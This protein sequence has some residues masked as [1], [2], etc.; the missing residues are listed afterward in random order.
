VYSACHD[1][2][3]ER[4][5]SLFLGEWGLKAAFAALAAH[6]MAPYGTSTQLGLAALL[7][8]QHLDCDNYAALTGHFVH[9]L[10]PDHPNTFAVI[11]LDGGKLGN[12]AQVILK[13]GQHGHI[14]ADPTVG[15]IAA[16]S[17]NKLLSGKPVPSEKVQAFYAHNDPQILKFGKVVYDTITSGRIRPSNMLYYFSDLQEY[18]RFS[19]AVGSA[20]TDPP[21]VEAIVRAFPTPGV[22]A[23]ERDL[24]ATLHKDKS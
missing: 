12:H 20:W 19:Y 9:I 11:G 22:R 1:E 2:L 15:I 7:R 3:S 24:T 5:A 6:E 4:L 8:E 16:T 17:Y 10:L 21:D 13:T 14:L 18:L 23:L